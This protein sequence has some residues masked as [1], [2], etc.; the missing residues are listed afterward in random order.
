MVVILNIAINLITLLN[1]S[2]VTPRQPIV[3]IGIALFITI[4]FYSLGCSAANEDRRVG[5]ATARLP[6]WSRRILFFNQPNPF[7]KRTVFFQ[8][9]AVLGLL[10]IFVLNV[11]FGSRVSTIASWYPIGFLILM[12]VCD[13]RRRRA[14]KNPSRSK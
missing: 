10:F 9:Y 12:V 3:V 7:R 11:L 2:E 14:V 8:T 6:T 5:I 1:Q 13:L 4:I